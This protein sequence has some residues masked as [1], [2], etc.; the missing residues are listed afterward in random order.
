M[1]HPVQEAE[2]E[3]EEGGVLFLCYGT[4][5]PSECRTAIDD[6]FQTLRLTCGGVL[7]ASLDEVSE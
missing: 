7:E 5:P 4:P 3:E 2:E 6:K 1:G